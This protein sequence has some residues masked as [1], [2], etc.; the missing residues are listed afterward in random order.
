[1]PFSRPLPMPLPVD[2]N[3]PLMA[4]FHTLST[5]SPLL[6][7]WPVGRGG[8]EGGRGGGEGERG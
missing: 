2:P 7:S 6:P 3:S 4:S 1:M 8:R 5:K